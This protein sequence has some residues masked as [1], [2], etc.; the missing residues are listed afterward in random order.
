MV[1]RNLIIILTLISLSAF[2]QKQSEK[3]YLKAWDY[4]N[5][6]KYE[7]AALLFEKSIEAGKNTN[8]VYLNAASS[9][10]YVDNKNKVFENLQ[11]L[12]DAGYVDKEYIVEWFTEFNKYKSSP[13]WATF[14]SQ[15]DKKRESFLSYTKNASFQVLTKEQMYED[16][17]VLVKKLTDNSPHLKI[18]KEVCGLSTEFDVL[19][20]Q[21]EQCDNSQ[22]FAVIIKKAVTNCQDGHTSLISINPFQ[23]LSEGK[24]T[25]FCAS[26]YKYQEYYE[27][28][29][30]NGSNLPDLVYH[31]GFYY[32]SKD[33]K[34][35]KKF[36]PQKSKLVKVD[37]LN[38]TDY[39]NQNL[40]NCNFLAWD[41]DNKT[42]YSDYFL[43]KKI[44]LNDSLELS[45]KNNAQIKTVKI[46][47]IKGKPN[48]KASSTYGIVSFWSD[49][50]ILYIRMPEMVN[51]EKY[52]SQIHQYKS[53]EIHKV[54][55]DIRNNLGGSD[56]EWM[57]VLSS[58][59]PFKQKIEIDYAFNKAFDK[60]GNSPQFTSIP[61]LNFKYSSDKLRL[62]NKEISNIGF[63]GKIYVLYNDY[64]YSSAGSL[65]RACSYFDNL[66]A[67][68]Y[69]TGRI[70]G[71]GSTPRSFALPNTKIKVRLNPTL[72]VT[73]VTKIEQV[74]HSIPEIKVNLTLEDKIKQ[75]NNK[76]DFESIKKIDP[77]IKAVRND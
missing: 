3:Y 1:K 73:G 75:R 11:K 29:I 18:Q 69:K 61:Y 2:S 44:T 53:K 34:N 67:V 12:V 28:L 13:E 59:T 35:E 58:I 30:T 46:K 5:N 10:A 25:S 14:I 23:Y 52:I 45:F 36:I 77:Y 49:E 66:V 47:L 19:R 56:Y 50:K 20:K 32:V 4:S 17:D 41:F 8:I 6:G 70:L 65:V 68:G 39:L 74:F 42:Y 7:K 37:G 48:S 26:L 21:I 76:A 33:Y 72:D 43:R 27:S 24:D 51:A 55:I 63:K 57:D 60:K 71:F 15:M 9:W 64:S 38:P 54:I 62:W 40:T 16:F 22:K 31:K